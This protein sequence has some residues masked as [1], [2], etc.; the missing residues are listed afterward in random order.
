MIKK[1]TQ[2]WGRGGMPLFMFIPLAGTF[3]YDDIIIITTA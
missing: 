1:K 2:L 3:I